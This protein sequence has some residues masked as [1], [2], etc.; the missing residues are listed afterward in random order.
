[1]WQRFDEF[2]ASEGLGELT[3]D[4]LQELVCAEA[5]S[6]LDECLVRG[7]ES[8]TALLAHLAALRIGLSIDV[9]PH[10][11]EVDGHEL[12]DNGQ[13]DLWV[14]PHSQQHT[15]ICRPL[16]ACPTLEQVSMNSVCTVREHVLT[17]A[18]VQVVGVCAGMWAYSWHLV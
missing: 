5:S 12:K 2:V 7:I 1:M 8:R 3:V 14:G 4:E 6:E 10:A 17:C 18:C 13:N 16:G 9:P 11:P 15:P